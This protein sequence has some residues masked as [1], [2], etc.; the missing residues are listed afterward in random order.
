[1]N[2]A[3]LIASLKQQGIDVDTRYFKPSNTEISIFEKLLG[4]L[5]TK[6][7]TEKAAV[8]NSVELRPVH[9]DNAQV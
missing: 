3:Q 6:A 9:P 7:K 5:T 2:K 4:K 8:I 1:M